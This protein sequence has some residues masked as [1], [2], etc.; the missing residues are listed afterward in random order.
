V[1]RARWRENL[2]LFLTRTFLSPL[3]GVTFGDWCTLLER[4]YPAVDPPYWLRAGLITALSFVNSLH[5]WREE[6]TFG[7]AVAA[8]Q[9][10][11]PLFILGHWRTGTTHLHNLLA[12]D[13][14]FAYPT[15]YQVFN[16]HTFLTTEA[17]GSRLT[18]F[19]LPSRRPQDDIRLT[20]HDPQ[21]DEYALMVLTFLSPCTGWA[22]PRAAEEYD[23]YLTF[24]DVPTR[25]V[26]RWQHALLGFLKKLTFKYNKPL[27][28]KSPPHTA[29][30][31][32]LLELFPDARFVHIHRNPYAVYQSTRHLID[33]ALPFYYLQRPDL[34]HVE[35]MILR[36]YAVLYD[37]FFADRGLI[38]PGQFHEVGYEDLEADPL[39][40]MERLYE[41]LNLPDFAVVRPAL[42]DYVASLAGYRKNRHRELPADLRARI[43]AAWAR[44]FA[45]WGYAP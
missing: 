34:R 29:R 35:E 45:A 42:A 13:S 7:A 26:R 15:I 33:T 18:G 2:R 3:T 11:P 27:L 1:V 22:L 43:A 40:E 19:L 21:E 16:P 39:G 25:T 30:I 5:R 44:Y 31:R 8:V 24:R 6:R 10:K 41:R 9:V 32:L 12:V 17:A 37:A 28:L 23:R 36:R 14:R 20:L 38:P 4:H